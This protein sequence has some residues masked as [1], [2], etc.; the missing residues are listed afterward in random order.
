MPN[1]RYGSDDH[2]RRVRL[3]RNPPVREDDYDRLERGFGQDR[4]RERENYLREE[5]SFSP[6]GGD[7]YGDY[8][9]GYGPDR[10]ERDRYE[11]EEPGYRSGEFSR[12]YG[13]SNRRGP[14]EAGPIYQNQYG[15]NRGVEMNPSYGESQ[16]G[17]GAYGRNFSYGSGGGR[18]ADRGDAYGGY[19]QGPDRWL[20]GENPMLADQ[21]AGHIGQ[22]RGRGPKNYVRSDERIREDVSD[23]LADHAHLD[24]SEIDV[25][26]KNGEVTLTGTVEDRM[27]KRRAEDCADDVSG[28]K[29]VQN[30]LR[31]KSAEPTVTSTSAAAAGNHSRAS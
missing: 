3:G 7:P 17:Y 2:E 18:R 22:H 19:R 27:S 23:R 11:R 16:G 9:K 26:V 10:F 14:D 30:N 29:H 25:Q 28:V 1:E 13:R 8:G 20:G 21:A 5:R 12:G 31:V 15:L 24:A 6:G 4:L